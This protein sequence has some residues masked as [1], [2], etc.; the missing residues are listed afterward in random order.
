MSQALLNWNTG[1]LI[2]PN[3]FR[4]LFKFGQS[5]TGLVIVH[6]LS[7]LKS[8]GSFSQKT[9]VYKTSTTKGLRQN[10]SLLFSWITPEIPS[11]FHVYK[12]QYILVNVNK[13]FILSGLEFPVSTQNRSSSE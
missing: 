13:I 11:Q 1:N 2:Q 4:K 10:L 8:L 7:I 9:V 6:A 3:I 5:G 12:L